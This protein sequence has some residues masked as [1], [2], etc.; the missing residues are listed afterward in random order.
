MPN[1]CE[2]KLVITGP[3]EEIT[4]FQ[5][6]IIEGTRTND[7]GKEELDYQ[8][9]NKALPM[10]AILEGTRHPHLETREVPSDYAKWLADEN[11]ETWTQEYY[12]E[13]VSSWETSYDKTQQALEEIG[14]GDWY[15]WQNKNWGTKWGDCDTRL[16]ARTETSLY[17]EY[18]TAWGPLSHDFFVS[19]SKRFPN[20]EFVN[21]YE[22]GGMAFLGIQ[23]YKEGSVVFDRSGDMP[24]YEEDNN[25]AFYE[26]IDEMLDEWHEQYEKELV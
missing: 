7:Y 23:C 19:V 21:T 22:E 11:N 8:L 13:R 15:T 1:W 24:P 26:G 2:N 4:A 9:C 5:D 18:E 12:D 17:F 14:I 10:P 3:A 25:L 20:L 16:I 6:L